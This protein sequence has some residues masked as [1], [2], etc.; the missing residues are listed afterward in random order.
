MGKVTGGD[1]GKNRSPV[2]EGWF[3]GGSHPARPSKGSKG[4]RQKVWG[5][6][7]NAV[8]WNMFVTLDDAG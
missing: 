3:A 6:Y 5:T 1:R 8:E 2:P 7:L 4:E